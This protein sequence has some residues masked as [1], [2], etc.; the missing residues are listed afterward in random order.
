MG[1]DLCFRGDL[2]FLLQ[3]VPK[4]HGGWD[5][6]TCGV[7]IVLVTQKAVLVSQIVPQDLGVLK[8]AQVYTASPWHWEC[9]C[10]SQIFLVCPFRGK[11]VVLVWVYFVKGRIG[12]VNA[13]SPSQGVLPSR[14]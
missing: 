7:S 1:E 6:K 14:P 12:D 13:D 11:A 9:V 5:T 8:P 2:L 3:K 10:L 4:D